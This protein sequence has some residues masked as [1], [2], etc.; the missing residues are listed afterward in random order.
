[1]RAA[2]KDADA[3]RGGTVHARLGNFRT[4]RRRET[5]RP[6]PSDSVPLRL[7]AKFCVGVSMS[8]IVVAL[9]ACGDDDS[10]V[11]V[12]RDAGRDAASID[13]DADAADEDASEAD[14]GASSIDEAIARLSVDAAALD[15]EVEA[16]GGWPLVEGDRSLFVTR[17]DA[18]SVSWVGTSNEFAADADLATSVGGYHYAVV[19]SASGKYKWHAAGDF[20]APPEARR[21]G[22]D[23]FGEHGWVQAPSEEHFE[24]YRFPAHTVRARI[25]PSPMTR[26][27]VLH[28]GQNLFGP[29]APFGGWAVDEALRAPGFANV[30]ALGIDNT[31]A[32]IDEY[33]HVADD[34]FGSGLTGGDADA[35]LARVFEMYLPRVLREH[36]LVDAPLAM[37]GSSLGGLVSLYAALSH[38]ELVAVAALSPTLGW[39]AYAADGSQAIESLHTEKREV[40]IYIDSGGDGVCLDVDGDGIQED[41]EDSDNFC[42]TSGYRDHLEGLGYEHGADLVHWH[43]PGATHDEMAWRARVPRMLEALT[44]LGW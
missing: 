30:L 44:T 35:Y 16:G 21:Y 37:G 22:Y 33:T 12:G 6:T 9:G 24:R 14:A 28:D 15:A 38:D 18:T 7:G 40:G 3:E 32:R 23:E 36:G 1:M 19:T 34:P 5:H 27:L 43:E 31:S 13:T 4:Q 2:S 39:G 10:I 29:D 25:S 11:D 42:V 17:W 26:V 41:S 8:F 20:R